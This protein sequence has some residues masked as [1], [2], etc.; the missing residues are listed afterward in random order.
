MRELSAGDRL[1]QYELT[2]LVAHSGMTSI[3]KGVD[4]LSELIDLGLA[5][6]LVDK[7]GNLKTNGR[8]FQNSA[9]KLASR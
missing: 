8:A 5:R 1:D 7:N 3:F 6:G 9:Q 2:E 4:T